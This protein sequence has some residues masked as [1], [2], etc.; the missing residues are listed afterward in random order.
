M[1]DR[2]SV[3]QETTD[4]LELTGKITLWFTD[5]DKPY[6]LTADEALT[7]AGDLISALHLVPKAKT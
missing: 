5:R 1:S 4:M 6:L 7:L 3:G 2:P